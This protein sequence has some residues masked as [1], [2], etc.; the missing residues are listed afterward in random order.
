[1]RKLK[2]KVSANERVYDIITYTWMLRGR[3]LQL[4][5][6]TATRISTTTAKPLLISECCRTTTRTARS[7]S[8]A[9]L[10][11]S[12]WPLRYALH[13]ALK[14]GL[15]LMDAELLGGTDALFIWY[16]EVIVSA[17]YCLMLA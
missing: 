9:T 5:L 17:Y 15:V 10:P 12:I 2:P 1:M 8:R 6:S 13:I 4:R 11:K 16:V 14:F 3:Q 7:P